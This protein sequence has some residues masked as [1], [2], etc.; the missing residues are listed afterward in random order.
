MLK[1]EYTDPLVSDGDQKRIIIQLNEKKKTIDVEN[2]YNKLIASLIEKV[3]F[4]LKEGLKIRY[5]SSKSSK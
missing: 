1:N 5:I 2:V 3:N 4:L